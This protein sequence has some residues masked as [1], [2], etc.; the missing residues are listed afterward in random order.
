MIDVIE[1]VEDLPAFMRALRRVVKTGGQV[2]LLT[3]NYASFFCAGAKWRGLGRDFEHLHYLSPQSLEQIAKSTGFNMLRW[4]TRGIPVEL[5]SY[6]QWLAGG[7][8]RWRYPHISARNAWR[9]LAHRYRARSMAA[10]SGYELL[11]ILRATPE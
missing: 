3:P 4:W 8:H 1:H 2:F 5:E 9:Q 7:A 11:A 6:P 10:A